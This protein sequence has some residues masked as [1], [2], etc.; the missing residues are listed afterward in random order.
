M[1]CFVQD[2]V[3]F[4]NAIGGSKD[5]SYLLMYFEWYCLVSFSVNSAMTSFSLILSSLSVITSSI[6]V[7]SM[8]IKYLSEDGWKNL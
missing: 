2:L 4:L 5:I 3:S 7:T 1:E 6:E 8:V